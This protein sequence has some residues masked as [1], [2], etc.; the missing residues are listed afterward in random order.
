MNNLI[1]MQLERLEA[2]ERLKGLGLQA[3]Y[4]KTVVRNVGELHSI[5]Y[6]SAADLTNLK[7]PA[8]YSHNFKM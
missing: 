1:S 8:S 2:L 5:K 3:F 7:F 4:T 6:L